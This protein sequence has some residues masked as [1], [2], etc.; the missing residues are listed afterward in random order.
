V[1][2]RNAARADALVESVDRRVPTDN[3]VAHSPDAGVEEG[4][5]VSRQQRVE[6]AEL[7]EAGEGVRVDHMGRDRVARK[8]VPVH[9]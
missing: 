2:E 7:A 4:D 9:Q 6:D 8:P 3:L 1:V 5:V